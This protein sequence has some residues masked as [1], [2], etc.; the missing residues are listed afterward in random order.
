M[1]V[2]ADNLDITEYP[3]AREL[4]EFLRADY[5]DTEGMLRVSS[6]TEWGTYLNPSF[7]WWEFWKWFSRREFENMNVLGFALNQNLDICPD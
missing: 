6:P 1:S 7:R 2:E 5:L 4:G 3:I